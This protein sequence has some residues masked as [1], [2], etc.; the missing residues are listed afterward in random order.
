VSPSVTVLSAN[1][2]AFSD[3]SPN[4][5]DAVLG[6]IAIVGANEFRGSGPRLEPDPAWHAS[7]S[8]DKP[9][10]QILTRSSIFSR[11]AWQ[12]TERVAILGRVKYADFGGLMN[13]FSFLS[14][15][16]AAALVS[17]VSFASATLLTSDFEVV[18]GSWFQTGT[19]ANPFGVA[20]QPTIF[21]SLTIDTTQTGAAEY[22]AINWKTGSKT[23]QVSDIDIADSQLFFSGNS[24]TQFFITFNSQDYVYSNN[25]AQINDGLNG[26]ACNNCVTLLDT[27]VTTSVPEPSS[28][29]M[30][31]IG[32]A[33]LAFAAYRR[34]SK[35]ALEVA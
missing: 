5:P 19:N 33:G 24:I 35:L 30:M 34:K 4:F 31:I 13:K 14:F 18:G 29:A 2:G 8:H 16:T 25:T 7:L 11:P 27:V 17:H 1:V 20:S 26:I 32:F 10:P 9:A 6:G 12:A 22:L 28:W 21:G 23:W 15:V 3:Q